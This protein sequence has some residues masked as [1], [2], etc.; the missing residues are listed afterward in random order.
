[1]IRGS[2]GL[3][4]ENL[5]EK[6]LSNPAKTHR[7]AALQELRRQGTPKDEQKLWLDAYEAEYARLA[8]LCDPGAF[9]TDWDARCEAGRAL[10]AHRI[11]ERARKY[12]AERAAQGHYDL[13]APQDRRSPG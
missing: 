7:N 12:V 5:T 2:D 1:M 3:D 6:L 11:A 4:Y 9:A 8:A 10:S 13:P